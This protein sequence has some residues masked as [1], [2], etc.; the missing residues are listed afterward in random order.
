[1]ITLFKVCSWNSAGALT[2]FYVLVGI[3]VGKLRS[4][5]NSFG[6]F[7]PKPWGSAS[8]PLLIYLAT[9]QKMSLCHDE[10]GYGSALQAD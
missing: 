6:H 3:L 10:P 9:F 2:L 5:R 1:M 7:I 8:R 4:D